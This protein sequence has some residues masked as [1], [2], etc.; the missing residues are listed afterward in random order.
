M[1]TKKNLK[2]G[3]GR[4][5]YSNDCDKIFIEDIVTPVPLLTSVDASG[6]NILIP[7]NSALC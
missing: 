5:F 2:N 3:S 7:D 4:M 6:S 1:L